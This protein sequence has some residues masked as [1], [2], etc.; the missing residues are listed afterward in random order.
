M[1][2][3]TLTKE[4]MKE[5]HNIKDQL[6]CDFYY[7]GFNYDLLNIPSLAAMLGIDDEQWSLE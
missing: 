5:K 2:I 4:L 1:L 3:L 7:R 6:E